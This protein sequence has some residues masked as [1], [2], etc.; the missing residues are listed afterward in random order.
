VVPADLPAA[1]VEVVRPVWPSLVAILSKAEGGGLEAAF[2]DRA[3]ELH[4]VSAGAALGSVVVSDI[5]ADV[6]TL[7]D[8][9]S[10]QTTRLAVR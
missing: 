5:S 9:A 2:T 7:T 1:P 6:V 10:G 8:Q 4:V 3:G